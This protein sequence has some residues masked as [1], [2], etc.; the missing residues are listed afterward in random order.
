MSHFAEISGSNNIVTRV[1]VAEQDFIDSGAVGSGSDWV[2]TSYNT[3][4]GV[5]HGDVS[6]SYVPDGGVALR[7]NYAG[8][9]YTY[10]EERDAFIPPKPF[11]SWILNDDTCVYDSPVER[12]DDGNRYIWNEDTTSWDEADM[13]DE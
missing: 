1:I 12:P 4:A 3:R 13:G 9:G 8:V 11:D 7:K 10:D 2:Q 5:H 6:G